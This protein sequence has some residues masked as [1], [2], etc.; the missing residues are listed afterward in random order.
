MTERL[1]A[2]KLL[3]PTVVPLIPDI[4]DFEKRWH[5]AR[6]RLGKVQL[7]F[8]ESIE[9]T[10]QN[11]LNDFHPAQLMKPRDLTNEIGGW[12]LRFLLPYFLRLLWIHEQWSVSIG[13]IQLDVNR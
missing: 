10:V 1:P 12:P 4:G 6:L 7:K 13:S 2:I 8:P 5:P 3:S 11:Q 9:E